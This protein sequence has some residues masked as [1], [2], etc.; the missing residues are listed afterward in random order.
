MYRCSNKLIVDNPCT[1]EYEV[2]HISA[3]SHDGEVAYLVTSTGL[4]EV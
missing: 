1:D 2:D 3:L 4:F